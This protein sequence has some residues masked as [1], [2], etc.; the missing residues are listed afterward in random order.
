MPPCYTNPMKRKAFSILLYIIS[1]VCLAVGIY[2]LIRQYVLIPGAYTPPPSPTP[3]VTP[4]PTPAA[5]ATPGIS[6]TPAASATPEPTPSPTPYVKPIPTRIYFTGYKI[7]ADIYPV[8]KVESGDRKGQMDTID[9]PD[10]AAWYEPGPAPG[11]SGNAL[12]N[13]HK[14]WKGKMGKF[15]VLWEMQV[16]DE[17]AIGFE[18]GTF[19]Y[20]YVVSVDFYPYNDVP[21]HVMSL[22]GEDRVTLITCYGEYSHSAGTSQERCVVVCQS[23]EII[24]AKE[25]PGQAQ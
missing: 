13:G 7:M 23:E 4:S 5:T 16:G 25:Q 2:L 10:V 11:E 21:E 1:G 22:G 20:F 6:A 14:S 18:D 3:V 19:R 24:A 15:A 9:D 8:G 17:I 12:I